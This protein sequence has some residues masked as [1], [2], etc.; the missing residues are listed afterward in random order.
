MP[1]PWLKYDITN[2]NAALF[3][4]K[5]IHVC[6][7]RTPFL[8]DIFV[9]GRD[10]SLV[11]VRIPVRNTAVFKSISAGGNMRTF[12]PNLYLRPLPIKDLYLVSIIF[13]HYYSHYFLIST[14]I[15]SL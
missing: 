12:W 5:K 6:G 1:H 10:R 7:C 2:M 9:E 13:F 4:N 11:H 8:G 14:S 3:K 15:K